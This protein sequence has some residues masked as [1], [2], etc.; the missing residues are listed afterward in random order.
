MYSFYHIYLL[1][2]IKAAE[3]ILLLHDHLKTK[4]APFTGA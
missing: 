3:E 2:S 1:L 4:K